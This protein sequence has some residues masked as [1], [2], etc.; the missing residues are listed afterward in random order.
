LTP[1]ESAKASAERGISPPG[2]RAVL[3]APGDGAGVDAAMPPD[4]C[5]DGVALATG[6][7]TLPVAGGVA[8]AEIDE[9]FWMPAAGTDGV[10]PPPPHAARTVAAATINPIGAAHRPSRAVINPSPNVLNNCL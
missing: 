1:A 2:T 4:A 9:T 8:G 10:E 7:L 3:V 6:A 5:G